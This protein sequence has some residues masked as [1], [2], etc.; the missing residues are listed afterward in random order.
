MARLTKRGFTLCAVA[1]GCTV[2]V[3]STRLMV[4]T[5]A[6]SSLDRDEV[7]TRESSSQA[8]T[9]TDLVVTRSV[10]NHPRTKISV[11]VP[12]TSVIKVDDG[13]RVVSAMTN[14][15]QPP[16]P[17]DALWLMYPDGSVQ[18]GLAGWFGHQIW[19][20]DFAVPGVFVAQIG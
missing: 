3:V 14:T 11:S 15:G 17:E 13:G 9:E 20:G 18:P 2:L 1:A 5:Y 7:S 6:A 10:A 16:R 12:A 4:P 19:T 8:W